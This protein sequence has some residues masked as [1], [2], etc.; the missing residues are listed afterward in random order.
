[1][2]EKRQTKVLFL[3]GYY[4]NDILIDTKFHFYTDKKFFEIFCIEIDFANYFE[5]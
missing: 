4:N 1:M 2:R 3:L 5:K